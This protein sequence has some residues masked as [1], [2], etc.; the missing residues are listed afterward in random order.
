MIKQEIIF[1]KKQEI[2]HNGLVS[3]KYEKTCKYLNYIELFLILIVT[4]CVSISEFVSL[5]RVSVGITS[6][7]VGMTICVITW[8]IK[9]YKSIIKKKKEIK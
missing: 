4:G 2:N 3:E 9:K 5:V 8:G 6:S 1:K 7:A